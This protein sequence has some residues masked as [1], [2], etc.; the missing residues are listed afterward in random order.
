MGAA[1]RASAA[2]GWGAGLL[3]GIGAGIVAALACVMT[4][5]L[6]RADIPPYV[7]TAGSA[8]AAGVLGG[9]G[10]AW[11]SRLFSRPA[12]ALWVISLAL[13]T[14]DSIFVAR[15]PFASGPNPPRW[16]PIVGLVAP[17]KQLAA[18]VGIGHFG[19]RRFPAAYLPADTMIHYVAAIAV[20]LLV[21][22]GTTG[23][24]AHAVSRVS[25]RG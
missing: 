25:P 23:G 15:L 5:V 14:L 22:W 2:V 9:L 7:Q 12:L 17:L 13:A 19:E 8:F 16:I 18:L 3:A 21:P 24:R 6:M 20:S 4:Q 11:L 1:N 10:Y